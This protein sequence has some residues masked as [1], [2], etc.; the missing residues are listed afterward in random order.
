MFDHFFHY[1]L[2]VYTLALALY[3]LASLQP[4][5]WHYYMHCSLTI[6]ERGKII[7]N[8]IVFGLPPTLV[9]VNSRSMYASL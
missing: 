4:C 5:V 7:K 2:I 1:S 9:M 8:A 6:Y 3:T